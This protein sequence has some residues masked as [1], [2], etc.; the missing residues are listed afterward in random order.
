MWAYVFMPD[1]VHLILWPRATTVRLRAVLAAIK[2]PV[3]RRAVAWVTSAAP[4]FLARMLD[5]QPNGT[6]A[7]RFW[8]R[9]G[10][11]D[12]ALHDAGT[13]HATIDYIHA[14]PVRAGLV[15]RPEQWR[16][17]RAAYFAGMD[18]PP[19]VPDAD[20]IPSPPPHWRLRGIT[21]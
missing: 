21:D 3:S 4:A 5:V 8:Q 13:I 14:N 9:G 16:W 19:L 7:Y 11:Y 2:L 12:R 10:G 15:A 18:T 6:R 17:S 20:S 1:H